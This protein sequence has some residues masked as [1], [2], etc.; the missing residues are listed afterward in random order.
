MRPRVGEHEESRAEGCALQM[1]SGSFSVLGAL[2]ALIQMQSEWP[3]FAA[4]CAPGASLPTATSRR[5]WA[6]RV[7]RC[8]AEEGLAAR[9]VLGSGGPLSHCGVSTWAPAL[10]HGRPARLLGYGAL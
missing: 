5:T 2:A 6:G 9:L 8:E 10:D 7:R 1:L 3:G 4:P